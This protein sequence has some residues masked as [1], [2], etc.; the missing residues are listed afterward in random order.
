MPFAHIAQ[1]VITGKVDQQD[2]RNIMHFGTDLTGFD[3][4]NDALLLALA[5]AVFECFITVL[6]PG[7]SSN[8]S[9]T[10][11][12]AKRIFPVVSDEVIDATNAG[13]GGLNQPCLPSFNSMMID[14]KTGGG[15]RRNR[16]RLFLPPPVEVNTTNSLLSS[17]GLDLVTDFAQC[18][19]GKFLG[20]D[21]STDWQIGVLS[22]AAIKNDDAAINVAFKAATS[23]TPVDEIAC[24]RRRKLRKGS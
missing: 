8:I 6:L 13:V 22:R 19:V 24:Q 2:Y 1:V 3:T 11:A 5:A 9:L 14:V 17:G 21:R 4:Q 20:L 15:G 23:L 10:G 16:G 7:L 18:M 12:K